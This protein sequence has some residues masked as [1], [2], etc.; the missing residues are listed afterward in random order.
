MTPHVALKYNIQT[1]AVTY[2][3]ATISNTAAIHTAMD[4]SPIRIHLNVNT[5]ASF[6]GI[7]IV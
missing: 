3:L 5:H 6:T 4:G 1:K 2:A 7:I